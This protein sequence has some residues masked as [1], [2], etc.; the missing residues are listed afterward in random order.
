MW[1]K[2]E[3]APKK[4]EL[5]E[6]SIAKNGRISWT[7]AVHRAL[8]NPT[9]VDVVYDEQGRRLGICRP[10][11]EDGRP[12]VGKNGMAVAA[13]ALLQAA[14][15][16]E[17]LQLP[18]LGIPARLEDGIWAI[19]LQGTFEPLRK[20]GRSPL[21]ARRVELETEAEGAR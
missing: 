6:I 21:Q 12:C 9:A 8:G 5:P 18:M 14:G 1:K 20:R 7:P 15:I 2:L 16:W 3:P 17:S 10:G 19:A 4:G 11:G 13:K